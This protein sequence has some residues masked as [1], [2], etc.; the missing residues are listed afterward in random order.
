MNTP[1]GSLAEVFIICYVTGLGDRDKRSLRECPRTIIWKPKSVVTYTKLIT[2]Y[3]SVVS[4]L[5]LDQEN[6]LGV[7]ISAISLVY[8]LAMGAPRDWSSRN[9]ET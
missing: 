6:I 5:L 1:T 2:E 4:C 7:N 8:S 3:I 9:F